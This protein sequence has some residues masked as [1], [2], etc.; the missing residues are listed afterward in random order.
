MKTSKVLLSLALSLSLFGSFSIKAQ[1]L[2]NK[3]KR[4][5]KAE[6]RKQTKALKR[7]FK[8]LNKKIKKTPELRKE[9]YTI[10]NECKEFDQACEDRLERATQD[11]VQGLSLI[12][13]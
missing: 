8:K 3:E 5:L 7:A 9:F 2:T 13:I 1:E 6:T 12:H 4:E 10:M 11:A